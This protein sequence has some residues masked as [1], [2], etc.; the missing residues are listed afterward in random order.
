MA[1]NL[2]TQA[3]GTA[4]L[5]YARELPWHKQGTKIADNATGTEMLKAAG[6]DFDIIT[7]D[8]KTETGLPV[9]GVKATVR[10]DTNSVIGVVG[11]GYNVFQNR[12]MVQFFEDLVRGKQISYEAA[13]GLGNGEKVWVLAR[14]PDLSYAI[15][16]DQ[17]DS[18][19]LI[20]NGHDGSQALIAQPT[21]TR[22]ICQN[23]YKAAS[24]EF[25]QRK[26]LY[27]KN[28][29][30]AGYQI[31]HTSNMRGALDQA[32]QAYQNCLNDAIA[33][34]ELFTLLADKPVTDAQIREYFLKVSDMAKANNDREKEK[35]SA[36]A[37]AREEK[38][39][40]ELKRLWEAPTNQTGTK[41]T[42]FAAYNTVVEWVDFTRGTRKTDGKDEEAARFESSMFGSGDTI[43]S[44][45]L[46]EVMELVGV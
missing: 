9:N 24:R 4:M 3:N 35:A 20:R 21:F 15:K 45:A 33:T 37:N 16:G 13:G 31:R 42:A 27:G 1:A 17:M 29:I 22:V 39:I 36:I 30:H 23:S 2:A 25:I 18:F 40:E 44:K 10:T 7:Q 41:G 12:E 11:N 6:L 14:I 26:K 43:K 8:L 46:L 5:A 38:R 28:S 34:K 19:M 32:L